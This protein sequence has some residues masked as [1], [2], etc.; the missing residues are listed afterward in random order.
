MDTIK[1]FVA[2]ADPTHIERVISAIRPCPGLRMAGSAN[3]GSAALRQI[4]QLSP[5]V[6]LTDVQLPKLDGLSLIKELGHMKRPPV[7]IVCTRFY[8]ELCLA[9]AC[10]YGASYLLYKP[11]DYQRLP[12]IIAECYQACGKGVP[13][14]PP[15]RFDTERVLQTLTRLGIPSRLSGALYIMDA[16]AC[17]SED[18]RLMKNLSSGLY[19]LLATRYQ[20]SG[21]C[22]E[23]AIRNAVKVGYERGSVEEAFGYQP[24]NREFLM[25]IMRL[26]SENSATD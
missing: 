19:P 21:A 15:A 20:T 10:R 8:S 4:T 1:I 9:Q 22:V 16:A 12:E 11:I 7:S 24:T 6:V 17:L 26:L 25:E 18:K 5:N 13:K 3:D 23:R 2:D 14:R